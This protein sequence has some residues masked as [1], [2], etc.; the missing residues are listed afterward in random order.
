M[1]KSRGPQEVKKSGHGGPLDFQY[2]I[3]SVFGS[4]KILYLLFMGGRMAQISCS[5]E[6]EYFFFLLLGG[7]ISHIFCQWEE[8]YFIYPVHGRQNMGGKNLI[9]PAYGRQK[10]SYF[11]SWEE[12]HL[13]FPVHGR[14]DGGAAG[15][16]WPACQQAARRSMGEELRLETAPL[17]P[18]FM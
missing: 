6:A 14:Q 17:L 16:K 2:I 18:T 13:I 11:L 7:K 9:F 8:E 12:K 15:L 5:W 4:Q 10:T 3:F 1:T